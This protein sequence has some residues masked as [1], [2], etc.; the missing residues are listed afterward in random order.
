MTATLRRLQPQAGG[1]LQAFYCR[2]LTASTALFFSSPLLISNST[3]P[4]NS[5]IDGW[6]VWRSREPVLLT[7]SYGVYFVLFV[8]S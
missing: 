7:S 6:C 8:T 1:C 2:C 4:L 3:F 5:E